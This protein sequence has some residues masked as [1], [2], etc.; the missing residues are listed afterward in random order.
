MPGNGYELP[1][2]IPG[3]EL[4]WYSPLGNTE[5]VGRRKYRR[6]KV[7]PGFALERNERMGMSVN[8]CVRD[9][10]SRFEERNFEYEFDMR[11]Q[12]ATCASLHFV[13]LAA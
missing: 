9:L 6:E 8:S 12:M 3:V 2:D 11:C 7:A 4:L 10:D 13:G 1:K 5:V